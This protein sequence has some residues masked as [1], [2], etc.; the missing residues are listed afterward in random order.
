ML[1]AVV[2]HVLIACS[3]ERYGGIDR[4]NRCAY[5]RCTRAGTI[6]HVTSRSAAVRPLR[7]LPRLRRVRDR[8][9]RKFAQPL[10][11]EALVH[12]ALGRA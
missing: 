8:I 11:V 12:G 6:P 7:D 10:D 9:D 5:H 3:V 2:G 4:P 1:D